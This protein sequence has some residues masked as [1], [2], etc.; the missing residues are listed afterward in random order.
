MAYRE[1]QAAKKME[2]PTT[3]GPIEGTAKCAAVLAEKF[4]AAHR[5]SKAGKA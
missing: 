4:D 2:N 1:E 5:R 3:R